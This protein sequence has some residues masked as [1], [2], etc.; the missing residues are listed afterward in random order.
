M[1]ITNNT[2]YLGVPR[3]GNSWMKTVLAPITVQTI[4]NEFP[5]AELLETHKNV[6]VFVR[7]PWSWYASLYNSIAAGTSTPARHLF[8]ALGYKPSF[9]DFV[10]SMNNPGAMYKRKVIAL[11]KADNLSE[12]SADMILA[13][14][15]MAGTKSLYQTICDRYY[16]V[17]TRLGQAENT[18]VEIKNMCMVADERNGI[19]ETNIDCLPRENLGLHV[20]YHDMYSPE[21]ADL[22]AASSR[23]LILRLNYR[24]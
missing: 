12:T 24:F 2:I 16:L 22:V 11:F 3:A 8:T 20:N 18:A 4:D 9:D 21:L 7:N 15:W 1:I 10:R 5:S 19:V 6:L 14:D 23:D 17:A 13:Q